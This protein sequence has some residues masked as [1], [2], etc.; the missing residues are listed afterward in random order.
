MICS[1]PKILDIK[2][3]ADSIVLMRTRMHASTGDVLTGLERILAK[4]NV[5]MGHL[6]IEDDEALSE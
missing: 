4:V 2:G 6:R 3:R 1:N 5:P